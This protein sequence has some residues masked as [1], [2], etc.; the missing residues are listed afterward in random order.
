M[1]CVDVADHLQRQRR[2]PALGVPHRRS[3]VVARRAEVALPV[4]QRR[5]HH[6]GLR[7]AHQGVV[8]RGVAVR[9][10][11][12]HDVADDARALGEPAVGTVATVV[13]RVEH[14]AVHRL[15]PVAYVGQRAADDDR[16]RVV[17]VGRCISS[18]SST[19]RTRGL[20]SGVRSGPLEAIS[21]GVVGQADVRPSRAQRSGRRPTQRSQACG[22]RRSSDVEEA[23]VF[24][25]ALDE[26]SGAARRPR[27]SAPRTSRRPGRR[28]RC[29]TWSISRCSGSIVVS[30]SSSAFI[31]PRP[32]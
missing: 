31:S 28:P 32:L 12:T 30:H 25:V 24:G 14:P 5:A 29:V 10:V 18:C 22:S 13:H 8:D 9:V 21:V 16:H 17:D 7:E 6:P 19:A 27:P 2:H 20:S 11:L 23:D 26:A 15:E 4:D 3:S 1:S